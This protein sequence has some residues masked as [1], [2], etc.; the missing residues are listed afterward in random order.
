MLSGIRAGDFHRESNVRQQC[1]DLEGDHALV[2]ESRL[3]MLELNVM[4]DESVD[5]EANRAW[6][7]CK[8]NHSDLSVAL[9]S[10]S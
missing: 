5:P 2:V 1:F 6:Q 8:R 10:S 7:D 9:P 3:R 4:L